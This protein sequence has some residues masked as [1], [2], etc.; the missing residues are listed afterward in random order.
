MRDVTFGITTFERPQLLNNLIQS[1][2][3]RYPLAKIVVANNGRSRPEVPDSVRLLNLPFDCGLSS[4]RNALVDELSTKYLLI[5]EDDFLFTDETEI[6]PLVDVLDSDAEVGAVGGALRTIHGRV[7]AYALDIEVFRDTMF[8][9]E[10]TH[11][12][13]VTPRGIPYRFCDMI[14][15]FALFRKEMLDDHRWIDRLKVGE[16]CPYYHQVKLAAKWRVA[17]CNATRI[18]HV[19][20]K[21]SPDYLKYRRRAQELFDSY[22]KEHGINHYHRVLPYHFEDDETEKPSLIVL[23]VGH[24]GTTVL[25]QMLGRAGW[26]LGDAD[27]EFSEHCAVRR[28][29]QHVEK[30]GHLPHKEARQVLDS[31]P[32]PWVIK[33]P[34]FVA[35]LHHWIPLFFKQDRKPVLVRI[36][37][38][39]DAVISSYQRRSAPGDVVQRVDMALKLCRQQQERWPWE[40]VTIEYERLA[41]AVAQF[42][43][44]CFQ[45]GNSRPGGVLPLHSWTEKCQGSAEDSTFPAVQPTRFGQSSLVVDSMFPNGLIRD[46]VFGSDGGRCL[47]FADG[48]ESF[49]A[50]GSF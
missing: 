46:S 18:Y 31:L 14:W 50:E 1:I 39:R 45:R 9:R 12:L 38:D 15:N 37:R 30:T 48:S 11:R 8:V 33:D 10:A 22:L 2:Y 43:M 35:T 41:A 26:N 42:D 29:N 40:R 25:T 16:H 5:L 17:A 19:P 28:L 49:T 27:K 13:N 47:P 3:R 4:A 21:R 36:Q 34:R 44:G 7:A 24:S 23:G 20:E 32:T 6:E